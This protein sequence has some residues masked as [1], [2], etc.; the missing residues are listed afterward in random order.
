MNARGEGAEAAKLLQTAIA[1]APDAPR[2]RLLLGQLQLNMGQ[3]EQACTTLSQLFE[4]G[5]VSA[6]LASNSLVRAAQ[7]AQRVPQTLELLQTH[8]AQAP[9][10]DVMDA[11]VS[12][13]KTNQA[14]D[15]QARQRY[16]E[17]LQKQ[18]SLLAA[19]RWL[20]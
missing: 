1:E 3:A 4:V 12:L 17:H 18:P 15:E 16:I 5:S 19:S 14:G 6:P 9:C 13:E 7:A 20:A 2:P 8:Y 11:I 10:I